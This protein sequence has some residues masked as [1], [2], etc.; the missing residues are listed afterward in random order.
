MLFCGC[1]RRRKLELS[2]ERT[3]ILGE[4]VAHGQAA[5]RKHPTGVG[6]AAGLRFDDEGLRPRQG[7]GHEIGH[8]VERIDRAHPPGEAFEI[9]FA[10]AIDDLDLGFRLVGRA[11]MGGGSTDIQ[12]DEMLG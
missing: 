11:A 12:D 3:E 8:D 4:L 7:V 2:V 1:L 5:G 6:V 10:L 9:A